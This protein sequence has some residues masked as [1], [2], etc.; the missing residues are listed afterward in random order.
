MNDPFR[1]WLVEAR[2]SPEQREKRLRHEQ[3]LAAKRPEK[4]LRRELRK[5]GLTDEEIEEGRQRLAR[6]FSDGGVGR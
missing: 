2:E 5:L 4:R 6:L 3:E 1:R